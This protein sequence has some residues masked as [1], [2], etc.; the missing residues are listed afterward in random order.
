VEHYDQ[1]AV[2]FQRLPFPSAGT[3]GIIFFSM[4]L[5]TPPRVP[6]FRFISGSGPIR[7]DQLMSLNR[8]RFHHPVE[9]VELALL[10]RVFDRACLTRKLC[11]RSLEAESMA[12]L[13]VDLFAHG[14]R[15]EH[16]LA[17]MVGNRPLSAASRMAQ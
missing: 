6:P 9:P 2:L 17:V 8:I 7:Q 1:K 12:V 15:Q 11:K 3:R 5:A 10:Q 4:W 13:L 16:H 14:V